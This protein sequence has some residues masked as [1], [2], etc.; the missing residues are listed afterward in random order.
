MS[1]TCSKKDSEVESDD[2]DSEGEGEEMD[3]DHGPS[4]SGKGGSPETTETPPTE[5]GCEESPQIVQHQSRRRRVAPGQAPCLGGGGR[6][7]VHRVPP[8]PFRC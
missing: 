2:F 3:Q 1:R 5:Q 6:L 4:Q 8:P 7:I